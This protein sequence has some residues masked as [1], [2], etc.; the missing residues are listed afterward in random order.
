[1]AFVTKIKKKGAHKAVYTISTGDNP[2]LTDN[3]DQL[4]FPYGQETRVTVLG[5]ILDVSGDM[6]K[7]KY[8][9]GS[10]E[11]AV[12]EQYFDNEERFISYLE[13]HISELEKVEEQLN[14]RREILE[15]IRPK[16][17]GK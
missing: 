2:K 8:H 4:I 7:D 6:K 12:E 10:F 16:K 1:M 3:D 11:A 5:D 14:K 13:R 15:M 17:K 9:K